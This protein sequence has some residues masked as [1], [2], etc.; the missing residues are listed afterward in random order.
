ML[1]KLFFMDKP[2]VSLGQKNP[3][4][5]PW[6]HLNASFVGR[7]IPILNLK[8]NIIVFLRPACLGYRGNS[9]EIN[10]H[11]QNQEKKGNPF[12]NTFM[13]DFGQFTPPK[14]HIAPENP[15]FEKENH[16]PNLHFGVPCL[17]FAGV[18]RSHDGTSSHC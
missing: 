18:S 6:T 7:C 9:C 14:T 4:Y 13:I 5:S 10:L 15:L 2:S 3:N 8:K 1:M 11:R 16:L 17:A 12:W